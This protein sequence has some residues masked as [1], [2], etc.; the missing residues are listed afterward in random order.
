MTYTYWLSKRYLWHCG[1]LQLR[2]LPSCALSQPSL[3]GQRFSVPSIHVSISALISA[4]ELAR[5]MPA[6]L[7]ILLHSWGSSKAMRCM[8]HSTT[9]NDAA[10]RV[11]AFSVP[12]AVPA[13]DSELPH[14]ELPFCI[15]LEYRPDMDLVQHD[16][17]QQAFDKNGSLFADHVGA[18]A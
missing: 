6:L 10:V 1:I 12:K 7:L 4:S 16:L 3:Y 18:R 17:P 8:R 13:S 15:E 5:S 11:Q 9:L 14:R 2:A